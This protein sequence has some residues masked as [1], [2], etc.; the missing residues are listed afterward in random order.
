MSRMRPPPP[1]VAVLSVVAVLAA[2]L[3]LLDLRR[4]PED[5]LFGTTG[6]A[7]SGTL[8]VA[9]RSLTREGE[10]FFWL[11]DSATEL[12]EDLN[13]SEVTRYLDARAAQGFT[14]VR[15]SL[16]VGADQYGDA[17]LADGEPL[18]TDGADP[19]DDAAY[20]FWDHVEFVVSEA[21]AR[22]MVLALSG[23]P[24][25]ADFLGGRLAGAGDV[26]LVP[27]DPRFS[28]LDG[29]SCADEADRDDARDRAYESGSPFVDG[30]GVEEDRPRCSDGATGA[31]NG[32]AAGSAGDA[33]AIGA[34]AAGNGTDV[35]GDADP[36]ALDGD[37][38]PD[39]P[40]DVAEVGPD[41]PA[42]VDPADEGAGS[43]PA[44]PDGDGGADEVGGDAAGGAGADAA[45]TDGADVIGADVIGADMI[46]ADVIGAD[47]IG[48]DAAGGAAEDVS[49]AGSDDGTA[50]V[51]ER[52]TA[53]DVRRDAWS[54]VLGGAAGA[55]YGHNSVWQFLDEG[56]EAVDGARDGWE[57]ALDAPG[58][59][60]MRHVRELVESR[61]R[62]EPR[63]DL[64]LGDGGGSAAVADDGTSVVA[65]TEGGTVEVDL[66]ALIG[67]AAQ[68]WWFD[69]RTGEAVELE[70]V[71]TDEPATFTPPDAD[72][73][74]VLVVDDADAGRGAP[75]D[76]AAADDEDGPAA[77]G[78]DDDPLRET[79]GAGGRDPGS[80]DG[81]GPDGDDAAD[82]D[83]ADPDAGDADAGDADAGD[84]DTGDPGAVDPGAADPDVAEDGAAADT[85]EGADG[86]G[87][88]ADEDD[89]VATRGA[90]DDP[91]QEMTGAGGRDP[92]SED[93]GPDGSDGESGTAVD[94]TNRDADAGRA[95]AEEEGG[96]GD[97]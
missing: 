58:A 4:S 81:T 89:P 31:P 66:T 61:P 82:P 51:G 2:A 78:G 34:D 71:A 40:D 97:G 73:D 5:C 17:P 92:G 35:A 53:R 3:L 28:V 48:A 59:E 23:G 76:P 29:D 57:E 74:W 96:S 1:L 11:A 6:C 72:E 65:Y 15:A 90:D 42:E 95:D 60:Q 93:D 30:V 18:V 91:L 52:A 12:L 25:D 56:R 21:S 27:G 94:E 44:A 54:A 33:S 80:E 39:G 8:A 36:A 67:D 75:G 55:T 10:P 19:R 38:E 13:R 20:D 70:P 83:T 46:G 68:P 24:A 87:G 43:G 86:A 69:P 7:G 9:G 63:D 26:V 32:D 77:T 84:P 64:V 85:G 22:G 41:G 14:V 79:T 88:A 47:V 16:E 49:G 62:L 50:T 45:G 37:A